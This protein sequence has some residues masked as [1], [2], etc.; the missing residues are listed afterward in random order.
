MQLAGVLDEDVKLL[1]RCAVYAY[2]RVPPESEERS[3]LK[4]LLDIITHLKPSSH[5]FAIYP[6]ATLRKWYN[7]FVGCA[8]YVPCSV[9]V[10]FVE[11][12][13]VFLPEETRQSWDCTGSEEISSHWDCFEQPCETCKFS[14]TKTQ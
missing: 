6:R 14:A 12:G 1:Y 7:A 9:R 10:H 13:Q 4:G 2:D 8:R 3:A 5:I 11:A